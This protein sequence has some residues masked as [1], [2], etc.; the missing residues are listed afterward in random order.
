MKNF[1]NVFTT[2]F[3][4]C[5]R[6]PLNV[7]VLILFPIV[8]IFVLGN[9]LAGFISPKYDFE[10]IPVSAVVEKGGNLEAF[11]QNSEI[12]RFLDVTFATRE[13]TEQLLES[14]DSFITVI[15]EGGEI[16]VIRPAGGGTTSQVAIST[17]DSYKQIGAAMTIAI[18]NGENPS[19][20]FLFMNTEISVTAAP[21]GNRVQS[22]IDY[23]AVTMLVMIL[24]FTGMNG[25]ELFKKSMFSETGA[26]V[27][28][29]PVPK[30]VLISGLLA[31]A[32]VTSYI[33]GLITFLFSMFVYGVY[34]GENIPLV[35]LTL[36]GVTL[37]SQAFAITILLLFKNPN[38]TMGAMQA[39]IWTMTFV[40]GGYVKM[41]FGAAQAIFNYSP[42]SLAH[43]V[44]FG[45]A[46][47]GNHDR[48][49]ADLRLLFIYTAVLFVIAFILGKRRLT[50]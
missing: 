11:L 25:L 17:I 3:K 14:G 21:L 27:L 37:F 41:D 5:W 13:E 43:T 34:W 16:S 12:S 49:M 20:L 44:I 8:L 33:Q 15:E 2:A 26:R 48:M 28:I 10:P 42:N 32:T 6:D 18:M 7:S 35:L 22:A 47:G 4:Y 38:A 46:F 45:S 30:P 19:E 9:A 24:L 50:S 31:A 36:F 1:L 23:Y 40:A 39:L 29:A